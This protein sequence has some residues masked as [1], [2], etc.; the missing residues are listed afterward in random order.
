[1]VGSCL[2]I[3]VL[4]WQEHRPPAVG[5]CERA[6]TLLLGKRFCKRRVSARGWRCCAA[7]GHPCESRTSTESA[8][9]LCC[10]VVSPWPGWFVPE[11]LR[12]RWLRAALAKGE[13]AGGGCRS[14]VAELCETRSEAATAK[15]SKTH[16][17]A[18][19]AKMSK[20]RSEAAAAKMSK[21]HSEAAAAGWPNPEFRGL[22]GSSSHAAAAVGSRTCDPSAAAWGGKAWLCVERKRRWVRGG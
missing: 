3:G 8:R 11:E 14:V 13:G 10:P 4:G 17:E 1:V 2:Q 6:V 15:M 21:T 16:S 20:T 12:T 9:G 22:L 18:A 19:T 5:W 7:W